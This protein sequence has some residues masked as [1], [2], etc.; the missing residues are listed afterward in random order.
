M[1]TNNLKKIMVT[2]L[3][4]KL[5]YLKRTKVKPQKII[6]RMTLRYALARA[7]FI[8]QPE[9]VSDLPFQVSPLHI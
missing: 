7:F 4:E 2:G 1:E 3:K 8:R 6:A 9:D 5:A